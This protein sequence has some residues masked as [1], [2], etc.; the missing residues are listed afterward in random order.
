MNL[1]LLDELKPQLDAAWEV[2]R[3]WP[4]GRPTIDLAALVV[5]K[6]IAVTSGQLKELGVYG[7]LEDG[8]AI[9]LMMIRCVE[10]QGDMFHLVTNEDGSTQLVCYNH[11][12]HVEAIKAEIAAGEEAIDA[13]ERYGQL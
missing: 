2:I 12:D 5:L 8:E 1:A 3:D 9:K 10:C 4:L 11:G 7:K 6:V 13:D